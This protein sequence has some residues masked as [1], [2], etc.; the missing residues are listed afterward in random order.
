M[1]RKIAKLCLSRETL[2]TLAR[3]EM[4]QVLGGLNDS[5]YQ[6]CTACI[7][8]ADTGCLSFCVVCVTP[9]GCK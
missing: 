4:G 6:S 5:N 8:S 7:Q 9:K 2:R 3:P 1:K